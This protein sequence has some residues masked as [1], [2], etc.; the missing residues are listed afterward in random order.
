[1]LSANLTGAH[2]QTWS[3]YIPHNVMRRTE[4][5]WAVSPVRMSGAKEVVGKGAS[6]SWVWA[7]VLTLG[8]NRASSDVHS[9]GHLRCLPASPTC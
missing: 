4:K 9:L 6:F 7:A 8:P 5:P 3:A 2:P 1:M